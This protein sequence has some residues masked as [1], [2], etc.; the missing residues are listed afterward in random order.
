MGNK[1]L[2]EKLEFICHIFFVEKNQLIANIK[3]NLKKIK[4]VYIP[5][6]LKLLILEKVTS[7][8]L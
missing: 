1:N 5:T 2:M 6:F 4:Q 7:S 3:G 8:N